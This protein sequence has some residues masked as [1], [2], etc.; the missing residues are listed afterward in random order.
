MLFSLM[1]IAAFSLHLSAQSHSSSKNATLSGKIIEKKTKKEVP[2]AAIYIH[3]SAQGGVSDLNGSFSIPNI[4]KGSYNLKITCLNYAPKNIE[5]HLD[6][7]TTILIQ[8]NEQSLQLPELQVMAT[9][10]PSKGSNAL[11]GQAA[12]EY[13]QPISL[14]DIFVLLPGNIMENN[15]MHRFNLISSRQVGADK[16]TSLGMGILTDGIPMTNDAMRTQLYGI[17]GSETNSFDYTINRRTELNAGMDMRSISTDYI[18][19][20]EIVRGISSAKEGNLSSGAIHITSKK[21]ETPLSIRAKADP[22]NKLIYAG[23]GIKLSDKAGF[24]HLGADVLSSTPDIREKLE[25]YTRITA[26]ANYTNI[27]QLLDKPLNI[28]AKLSATSSVS[29][30]KSDELI[31]ENDETYR[32]KYTRT[33]LSFKG[34]WMLNTHWLE[35]IEMLASADYTHDLLT[36]HK[37]VLSSIGP[38]SMPISIEP[39]EHE[40]V[41]L[42]VKYYSDYSVDNKPLYFFLQTVFTSRITVKERFNN[43]FQ[44]GIDFKSNKNLGKGAVVD[45]QRPPYPGDNTFIRPRPNYTIPA[46]INAAFFLEDKATYLIND[47]N[48]LNFQLGLRATQMLNLPEDFALNRKLLI[49]PRLQAGYTNTKSKKNGE[50]ISNT[51]RIGYGEENKLPTLDMIYPDKLY[52]DFNV[53]NAYFQD[54]ERDYL[55]VYTYIH[56]PEKKNLKENK[57]RKMEIG[58]DFAYRDFEMSIS[59]FGEVS[60]GGFSYFPRYYPVAFDRYMV[61]KHPVVGK[62]TKDDYYLEHY[63]DFTLFSVVENSAKTIKRGAEYRIKIPRINSMNTSIEV[64]GAYYNTVYTK[65]IPVMY[66]PSVME[67]DQKYP[68]VG[69]YPGD[70]HLHQSRLNTNIWINTHFPRFGLVFTNFIQTVWFSNKRKGKEESVLPSHYLDLDGTVHSVDADDMATTQGQLRYLRRERSELYYRTDTKPFS[71]FWNIKASKEIGRNAKLSFFVNK[72]IDINPRY[73]AADKT[74]VKEWAIPYFGAELTIN[75]R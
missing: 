16:S 56:T 13:I 35:K 40:G 19:S 26:Q 75:I 48:K 24:I 70:T 14:T 41:F 5:I 22:L 28:S 8:L 43:R 1:S 10:T 33:T 18:E 25:R 36:R 15:S 71:L 38:S 44:Y 68:Y 9:F 72:L 55:L 51:F 3:E 54:P 47:N 67:F 62:P 52:R 17:S 74:T 27:V 29:N 42:P 64:N 31:K 50:V 34:D 69:I 11:I 59:V 20:I 73:K 12:L 4:S 49:E 58:W 45:A 63:K 61:L 30:V 23:K 37:M 66:R 65:G 2:F 53:L 7:D 57:N 32:S 6:S 60:R 21:G 39:G 46:M